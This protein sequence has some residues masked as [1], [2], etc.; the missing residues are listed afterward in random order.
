M[1]RFGAMLLTCALLVTL[2]AAC[3][4][5]TTVRTQILRLPEPYRERTKM[6]KTAQECRKTRRWMGR[7]VPEPPQLEETQPDA[8]APTEEDPDAERKTYSSEADAALTPD[9][10]TSV[11]SPDDAADAPAVPV[12]G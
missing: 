5:P 6:C 7:K 8:E 10:E 4:R 9:A 11:I 1:K 12:I 2:T 3:S